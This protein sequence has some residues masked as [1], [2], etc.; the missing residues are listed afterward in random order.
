[1]KEIINKNGVVTKIFAETFEDEAYKQIEKICNY[2]P[3]FNSKIRIMPDAH[4][5]KGCVI[6][7]TMKLDGAVTPN[8][9]GVDIGCGMLAAYI[10]AKDI[11]LQKLDDVIR[12]YV[13][14][15][16]SVHETPVYDFN[17]QSL[18]CYEVIKGKDLYMQQS[19]GS[20]GGGN[21]FIEVNKTSD[22]QIMIVIH[23]G[24]RNLGVQVCN[25]Y[26][27]LAYE[28]LSKRDDIKEMIQVIHDAGYSDNDILDEI[29]LDDVVRHLSNNGYKIVEDE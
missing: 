14:S 20:L 17:L 18:Y 23:S 3:Y 22:G 28:N 9:V 11:D 26:Q 29:D 13:P 2:E 25:Y 6:G 21:H 24:S 12:K 8:M 5:G 27:N 1:M 4:A 19:L 15:G 16:F 10:T 7:T